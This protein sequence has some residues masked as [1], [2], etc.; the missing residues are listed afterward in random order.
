MGDTRGAA[1]RGDPAELE[2]PDGDGASTFALVDNA[3]GSPQI[4]A[5]AAHRHG[6]GHRDG[7]DA[8]GYLHRR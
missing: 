8:A 3:A 5:G 1:T 7:P 6:P 4:I 2:T